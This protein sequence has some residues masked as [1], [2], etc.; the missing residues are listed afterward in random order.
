MKKLLIKLRNCI[1][2]FKH[3]FIQQNR[4]MF[5]SVSR[6]YFSPT[7]LSILTTTGVV[8]YSMPTSF[9]EGNRDRLRKQVE[10]KNQEDQVQVLADYQH[11][12]S[13]AYPYLANKITD[14]DI[15]RELDYIRVMY[16]QPLSAERRISLRSAILRMIESGKLS[17]EACDAL[18]LFLKE[19]RA[20]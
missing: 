18:L 5:R 19:Y 10:E 11:T 13:R 6:K 16:T 8:A 9:A 17:E 7:R 14:I 15:L 2:E 20:L 3:F 12:I 1:K 4:N